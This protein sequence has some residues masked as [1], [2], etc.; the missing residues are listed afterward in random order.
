MR[1]RREKTEEKIVVALAALA[2]TGMCFAGIYQAI[3]WASG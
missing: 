2:V 3:A 1:S